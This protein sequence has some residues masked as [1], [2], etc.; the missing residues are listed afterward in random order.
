LEQIYKN[1]KLLII[2][3]SKSTNLD[4]AIKSILNFDNICLIVGGLAKENNFSILLKF[5]KNIYKCYL[6]GQSTNLIY[7]QISND[8]ESIKSFNLENAVEQIF[9]DIKNSEKKMTILLSPGC[10]SFDQ[11]SSYESRG[12]EFKKLI[13]NKIKKIKK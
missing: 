9:D 7:D 6:I 12:D 1:E 10:A 13:E 3:N 8:I 4:S 11:F 5:K 2:N